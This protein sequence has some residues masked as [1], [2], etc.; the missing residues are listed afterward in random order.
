MLTPKE[1]IRRIQ[2][3]NKFVQS[4]MIKSVDYGLINGFSKPTLLKP[5]AE[6]L[7][8]AFGFSIAVDVVNHIEQY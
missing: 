7:C 5:G 6:K 2:A 3:L 1:A 4:S 8:D